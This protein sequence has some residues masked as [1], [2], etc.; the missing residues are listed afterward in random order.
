MTPETAVLKIQNSALDAL[1]KFQRDQMTVEEF[2][3]QIGDKVLKLIHAQRAEAVAEAQKWQPISTAPMD[4]TVILVLQPYGVGFDIFC[5][6]WRQGGPF[7][8]DEGHWYIYD[9]KSSH[10]LRGKMPTRWMPLLA[11][12]AQEGEG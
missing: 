10:P 1:L 6:A 2:S 4:G 12:P 8:Y 5:A 3:T 9:G 7:F 11:P